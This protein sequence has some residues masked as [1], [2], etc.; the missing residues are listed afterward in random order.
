MGV[1]R[2]GKRHRTRGKRVGEVLRI[3]S[4][5]RE[6]KNKDTFGVKRWGE[7]R[8]KGGLI[9]REGKKRVQWH[10]PSQL[11]QIHMRRPAYMN[12]GRRVVGVGVEKEGLCSRGGRY[13]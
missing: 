3:I 8:P 12:S 7:K 2:G 9:V 10:Y 13:R 6:S 1:K 11:F 4:L 5:L